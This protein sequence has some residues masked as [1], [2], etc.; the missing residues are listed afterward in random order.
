MSALRSGRRVPPAHNPAGATPRVDQAH[1]APAIDVLFVINARSL[2]LDIAGQ[3]EAYR[4]ANLHRSYQDL[5]P[6]FRLRFA[7]PAPTLTTSTGLQVCDLEPLPRELPRPTWIVLIGQP[8]AQVQRLDP[9]AADTVRWLK[10]ILGTRFITEETPH[11]LVTICSGAL[12][13]ARAGLLERKR[14]TT[15]H[16]LLGLL[17]QLAPR[18]LVEDNRVFVLDGPVASSAGIT[19]GIDLALH[20]VAEECGEPL[21]ATVATD[22]V[23]YLRRS[24]RDPELSPFLVYRSHLHPVVHR[25]QDA[26]NLAPGQ[27]WTMAD[28]STTGHVT[29]RHLLRLF[30]EHAG[31]S[32]LHYL[33]GIRL[34]FARQALERGASVTQAA[35]SAGFTSDLQLRRTWQ[36]H[37]GGTPRDALQAEDGAN[38]S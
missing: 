36:R 5:P 24:P 10:V 19:A 38:G 7:G 15:H 25:V 30:L 35:E 3:A 32:P 34:A 28:L 23:V 1:A 2:L 29:P 14:C 20:L 16:E 17:R 8:A 9:G 33:Q 12:L 26:V 22:M 18:A 27:A 13:A 31:I 21:A 37:W 4:L 11:R 6:R